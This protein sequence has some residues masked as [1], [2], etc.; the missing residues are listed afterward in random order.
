MVKDQY[1]PAGGYQSEIVIKQSRFIG[2]ARGVRSVAQARSSIGE[3]R[4][5]HPGCSHV[6]YAFRV[7]EGNTEV[8]GMSDDGE[9]KGTAG[10]PVMEILK[11]SG[12]TNVLIT[13]VRYFGG[14]KLGTGGLVRAYGECARKVL[15]GLPVDKLISRV[16]VTFK[17]PYPWL[18]KIR[19]VLREAE[20]EI[21]REEYGDE[22]ILEVSIP[23]KNYPGCRERID[24]ISRGKLLPEEE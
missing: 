9:P 21:I 1:I 13:V 14:T 5:S 20:G 18:E 23:E 24:G 6:V 4:A 7:G 8:S 16:E 15:Q 10:R 12:I 11:G 22:V 17:V 3:E 19:K 2:R